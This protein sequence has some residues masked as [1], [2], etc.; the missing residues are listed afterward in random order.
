MS[1]DAPPAAIPLPP[2]PKD[3]FTNEQ[4][5]ILSAIADTV[6]PSFTPAKGNRLLQHPL[7]S[8]VF[9]EA[10]ARLKGLAGAGVERGLI[11]EYLGESATAQPEFKAS[12]VRVL[13]NGMDSETRNKLTG[14]LSVLK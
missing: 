6:V 8:E 3:P 11:D 2:P 10:R 7:R 13:G 1:T 5:G 14:V 12:L 9:G 4:W